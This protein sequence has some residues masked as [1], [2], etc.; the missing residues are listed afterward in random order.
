MEVRLSRIVGDTGKWDEDHQF[1]E[2]QLRKIYS[3]ISSL[4]QRSWLG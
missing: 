4:T 3:C 1:A 2:Q